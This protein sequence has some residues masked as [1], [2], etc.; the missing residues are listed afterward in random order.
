MMTW[1]AHNAIAFVTTA[2]ILVIL[3]VVAR[4]RSRHSR[5]RMHRTESVRKLMECHLAAL[6]E[7]MEHPKASAVYKEN[8]LDFSAAIFDRDIF[9][10]L[11]RIACEGVRGKSPRSNAHGDVLGD[12]TA[13]DPALATAYDAAVTSAITAMVMRSNEAQWI[14]NDHLAQVAM[15]SQKRSIFLQAARKGRERNPDRNPR[16]PILGI[17]AMA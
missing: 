3:Y 7:V 14:L 4:E 15:D 2:E 6:E 16:S 5:K 17:A 9:V 1:L 8:L 10:E 12:L 13:I 11:L